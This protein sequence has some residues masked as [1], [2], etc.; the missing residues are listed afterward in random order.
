MLPGSDCDG[1]GEGTSA[2]EILVGAVACVASVCA[3][4]A[5]G[6]RLGR[7]VFGEEGVSAVQIALAV[8]VIGAGLL[9]ASPLVTGDNLTD[10]G[11][12][13]TGGTLATGI[14]LG[15]LCVAVLA[16]A[17]IEAFG[18]LAGL[19]A[20]GAGLFVYPLFALFALGA[21]RGAFC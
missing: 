10:F 2:A 14:L 20:L 9:A 6:Y 5:G 13:L 8:L 4:A 19:Y 12:V 1:S 11:K 18:L 3:V 15:I 17:R 21:N 7:S 16:R